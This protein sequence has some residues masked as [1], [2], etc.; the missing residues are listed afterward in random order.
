MING[1]HLPLSVEPEGLSKPENGNLQKHYVAKKRRLFY[2]LVINVPAEQNTVIPK[3]F[4]NSLSFGS[5]CYEGTS[6]LK[7]IL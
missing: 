6:V 2:P 5:T 4:H 7:S 3:R 1:V